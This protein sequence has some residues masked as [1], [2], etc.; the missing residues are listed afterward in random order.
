[1]CSLTSQ[2]GNCEGVEHLAC[3][4]CCLLYEVSMYIS[5]RPGG[6]YS[7]RFKSNVGI[8]RGCIHGERV[9]V[10][11]VLPPNLTGAVAQSGLKHHYLQVISQSSYF[12][13]V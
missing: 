3:Y 9:S 2:A 6:E 8:K 1:M 12:Q 11:C 13:V 7:T 10:V 4:F 5:Y